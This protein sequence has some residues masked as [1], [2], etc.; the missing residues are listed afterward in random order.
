MS[1]EGQDRGSGAWGSWSR[2]RRVHGK[3]RRGKLVIEWVLR[4]ANNRL[5]T[6]KWHSVSKWWLV[7][8]DFNFETKIIQKEAILY[9]S[10]NFRL[11]LSS[12]FTKVRRFLSGH[13]WAERT[14]FLHF[15]KAKFVLRLALC[16]AYALFGV[17]SLNIGG[18][19]KTIIHLVQN[20]NIKL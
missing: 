16:P 11:Y 13:K 12:G 14:S 7:A 15:R 17:H 18:I 10:P 9:E 3:D 5:V 6:K 2:T 4:H 20:K 19:N 1:Q 8:R